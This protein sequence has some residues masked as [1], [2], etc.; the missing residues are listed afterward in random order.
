MRNIVILYCQERGEYYKKEYGLKIEINYNVLRANQAI[1]YTLEDLICLK[2]F[3]P[4][5]LLSWY[6]I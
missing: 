2:E 1:I 5:E 4:V 3:H 6:H